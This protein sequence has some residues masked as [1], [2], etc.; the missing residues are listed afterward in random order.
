[1][2]YTCYG[3]IIPGQDSYFDSDTILSQFERLFQILEFKTEYQNPVR[4]NI[5]ILV[6]NARTHTALS[7]NIGYLRFILLF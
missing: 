5:E 1:M 4:S 6:D 3:S 7:V 2:K